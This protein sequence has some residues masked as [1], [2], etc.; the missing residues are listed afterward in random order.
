MD[1]SDTEDS[2]EACYAGHPSARDLR[3]QNEHEV[4][5]VADQRLRV[6]PAALKGWFEALVA[7]VN[8]IREREDIALNRGI[9]APLT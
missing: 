4:F 2:A 7:G 5:G 3:I 6:H 1:E 8:M 9:A